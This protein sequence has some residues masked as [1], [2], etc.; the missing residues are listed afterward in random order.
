[1]A[2]FAEGAEAQ[3]A[4]AAGA[5]VVGADDLIDSIKESMHSFLLTYVLRSLFMVEG[6]NLGDTLVF[7][8]GWTIEQIKLEYQLPLMMCRWGQVGF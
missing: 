1:V 6:V 4:I 2:V 8:E 5:D 3:E 7:D